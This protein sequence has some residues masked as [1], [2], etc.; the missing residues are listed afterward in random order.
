MG[1]DSGLIRRG[2]KN[3]IRPDLD[4][5][6]ESIVLN[7]TKIRSSIDPLDDPRVIGVV[8]LDLLRWDFDPGR[9]DVPGSWIDGFAISNV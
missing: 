8:F 1:M 4:H 3:P 7:E 5:I 9:V 6:K 2:M